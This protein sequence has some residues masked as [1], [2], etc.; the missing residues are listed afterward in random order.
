MARLFKLALWKQIL[1]AL[2]AGLLFS[3]SYY[4]IDL[5]NAKTEWNAE[6]ARYASWN[7]SDQQKECRRLWA[8]IEEL[9]EEAQCGALH[10]L[11]ESA[12]CEYTV[13]STNPQLLSAARS[14]GCVDDYFGIRMT[15]YSDPGPFGDWKKRLNGRDNS[16][17]IF[18]LVAVLTIGVLIIGKLWLLESNHGW[19]RLA[20]VLS[21]LIGILTAIWIYNSEY[22]YGGPSFID[23]AWYCLVPVP[24]AGAGSL[25]II[26]LARRI[27][28][29]VRAGFGAVGVSPL[30]QTIGSLSNPQ[31]TT[32]A[33]KSLNEPASRSRLC[34]LNISTPAPGENASPVPSTSIASFWDRAYARGLDFIPVSILTAAFAMLLPSPSEIIGGAE[35]IFLERVVFM[36]LCCLLLVAYDTWFLSGWGTTPGKALLGIHVRNDQGGKLPRNEAFL[37]AIKVV[38]SGMWLTVFFPALQIG[39]GLYFIRKKS[40]PWDLIGDVKVC[41]NRI[42]L[43][44]RVLLAS[45]AIIFLTVF[46]LV[47]NSLRETTQAEIHQ[48]MNY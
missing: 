32:Q 2:F 4:L 13:G 47:Q 11:V 24:I 40:T 30:S 6:Y 45:V 18:S 3:G 26:L 35:G 39:T 21:P 12:R 14:A 48:I 29:W 19:R 15:S 1:I 46:G 41:Q 31:D 28:E 33:K 25:L 22:H 20:I 37:R 38:T 43:V 8:P 23:I 42:G 27:F 16:G 9:V 36:L 7:G 10:D 17:K 44:R 5:Y 34:I